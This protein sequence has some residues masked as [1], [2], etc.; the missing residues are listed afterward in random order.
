M[1]DKIENRDDALGGLI[2]F[3][4]YSA[5]H[6]MNRVYKPHLDAIGLTYPQ[7][8]AMLA[9]WQRDDQTVGALCE[10][11]LLESN[12]VTP[13]LKRLEKLGHIQ[14]RRAKDDERQVRVALT[15][16]GRALQD[17]ASGIG[18]CIL[19][20]TAMGL[21]AVEAL[22]KEVRALREALRGS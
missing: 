13:L 11:L 10:A 18:T 5:N 9:L 16:Q 14:R 8:L 15:E 6:A 7:Y 1:A 2:C 22:T 12:T 3:A 20:S 17:R 4:L 19:D 21:P